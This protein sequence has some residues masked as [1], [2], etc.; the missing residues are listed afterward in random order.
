MK[1]RWAE[2]R[3]KPYRENSHRRIYISSDVASFVLLNQKSIC[4]FFFI[5]NFEMKHKNLIFFH[6]WSDRKGKEKKSRYARRSLII[7]VKRTIRI[8]VIMSMIDVIIKLIFFF[9]WCPIFY[10]ISPFELPTI[11]I[12][13]NRV[14]HKHYI[15]CNDTDES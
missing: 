6:A 13:V 5:K 7:I 10:T 12:K 9:F 3:R 11:T 8:I 14:H 2:K 15:F 1:S 4:L